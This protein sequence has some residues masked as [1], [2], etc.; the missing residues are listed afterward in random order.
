MFYIY[1]APRKCI[2]LVGI[3]EVGRGPIAG[4]VAVAAVLLY[5]KGSYSHF[6]G[7][8]DSKKLSPLQRENW[9]NK[10]TQLKDEQ[11]LD[12]AVS[13]VGN[14]MIDKCGIVHSTQ[15]ALAR[16]LEQI[17]VEPDKIQVLL[18]GGL[19]APTQFQFQETI[20]KGDE[21]EPLIAAASIIAKVSRDRKMIRYAQE[22]NQYG[23]EKHK[24]Y[25]TKKHYVALK[26]H[27]MC[28]LHRRSFL[29]GLD[30]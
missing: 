28:Q 24:G 9:F 30:K 26:K 10:I 13:F 16:A 17:C 29:S 23:F 7:I 20:I 21:K 22:F 5:S 2:Y 19:I 14:E 27:G 15:S 6:E 8:K 1:N 11:L 3:D 12:F 4:P 18:D 25:G